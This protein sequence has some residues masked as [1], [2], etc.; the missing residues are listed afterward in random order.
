MQRYYFDLIDHEPRL[1]KVGVPL[2]SDAA[3]QQEA[4]LR[5][6]DVKSTHRLQKYDGFRHIRVRD[7]AGRM[8]YK[9][10]IDH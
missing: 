9:V 7:E 1:D 8:I 5:A 4:R 3:A 2:Q 6:L 10:Q